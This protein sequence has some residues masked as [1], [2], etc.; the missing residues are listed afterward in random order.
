MEV[1]KSYI[2]LTKSKEKVIHLTPIGD[3]HEDAPACDLDRLNETLI[4]RAQLP[5]SYFLG[6]GDFREMIFPGDHRATGRSAERLVHVNNEID[7]AVEAMI[8]KYK[9][10]KWLSLGCGNHE[11]KAANK[12]FT[13]PMYRLA[14]GIGVPYGR[15]AG[16]I[17]LKVKTAVGRT[18]GVRILYHHGFSGSATAGYTGAT[19]W[20]MGLSLIH[21]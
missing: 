3:L 16:K 17:F 1:I 9:P 7:L 21:I 18:I 13:D 4:A 2:D 5:N 6:L 15:Y 10:Y 14:A 19:K 12:Y 8:A 11:L 20:A